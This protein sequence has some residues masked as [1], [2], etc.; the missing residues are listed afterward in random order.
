MK[1][2]K[3]LLEEIVPSDLVGAL[4]SYYFFIYFFTTLNSKKVE[5]TIYP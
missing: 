2:S 3:E 1:V 5:I 4:G